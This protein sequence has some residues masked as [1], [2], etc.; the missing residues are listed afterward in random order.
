MQ[1]YGYPINPA[2]SLEYALRNKLSPSLD[3]T[4]R[5]SRKKL[6]RAGVAAM[7]AEMNA[8]ADPKRPVSVVKCWV[9]GLPRDVVVIAIRGEVWR[10]CEE[11][12]HTLVDGE[13]MEVIRGLLE[14]A[15]LGWFQPIQGQG[16][17]NSA[18]SVFGMESA[19][20]EEDWS[21]TIKAIG[22]EHADLEDVLGRYSCEARKR[23]QVA[24]VD[25]PK[26]GN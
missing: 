5:P 1:I 22:K 19:A 3:C 25:I 4:K 24:R 11:E 7:V 9:N 17:I 2:R 10:G 8:T 12:A 6:C 26:M 20:G 21:D 14:G 18:W 15:E 23:G 16:Q 13:R